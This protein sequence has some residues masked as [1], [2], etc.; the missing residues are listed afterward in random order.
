M[1]HVWCVCVNA[2]S[3]FIFRPKLDRRVLCRK[4]HHKDEKFTWLSKDWSFFNNKQ[5]YVTFQNLMEECLVDHLFWKNRS[6]MDN[7]FDIKS[8]I[9]IVLVFPL[10]LVLE[11]LSFSVCKIGMLFLDCTGRF[12]SHQ[13]WVFAE[14]PGSSKTLAKVSGTFSAHFLLP[15]DVSW[16]CFGSD[17]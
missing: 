8:H 5:L 14:T 3:L 16:Y 13:W 17:L 10:I 2:D 11:T 7:F 12:E 1:K 6:V 15:V 9:V 4:A